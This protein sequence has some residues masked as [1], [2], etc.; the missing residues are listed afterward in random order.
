MPPNQD[1]GMPTLAV[2]VPSNYLTALEQIAHA[3]SSPHERVYKSEITREALRAHFRALA[4]D[5][6]LPEETRDL[7][8]DDLVADGG[9][10]DR[11]TASAGGLL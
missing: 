1:D 7:L 5:D 9:R 8:D 6:E 3:E 10:V 4:D 11:A 2:R